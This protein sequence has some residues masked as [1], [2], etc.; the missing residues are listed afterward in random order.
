[1][2]EDKLVER[3]IRA[4]RFALDMARLVK[5]ATTWR[6]HVISATGRPVVRALVNEVDCLP[7]DWEQTVKEMGISSS[8]T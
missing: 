2:S 7:D 3:T 5:A 6:K 8:P 4:E 1:M